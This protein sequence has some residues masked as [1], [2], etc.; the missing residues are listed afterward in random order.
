EYVAQQEWIYP[1]RPSMRIVRDTIAYGA[2]HLP[3]YNPINISGYHISEAGANAIQEVAFTLANGIAYVEEVVRA[4]VP[5][6]DFAPRLAFYFI[7]QR[8][9]FEEIAKF[10]AARRV[11]AKV[12]KDRF[13]AKRAES[14]RIRFQSQNAAAT[15]THAQPYDNAVRT[16]P[17]PL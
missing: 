5:V 8:D 12:M 16:A 9:F 11:W 6:D 10:R 15:L 2:R 4:G 7:A 3:R 13:G 17:Q 14:M 1:L